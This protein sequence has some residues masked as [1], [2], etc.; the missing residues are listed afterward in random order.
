MQKI[1]NQFVLKEVA[2][3][4]E[5][6]KLEYVNP[7]SVKKEIENLEIT[8]SKED[9]VILEGIV[10]INQNELKLFD[11]NKLIEKTIASLIFYKNKL[12]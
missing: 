6:Y 7:V 9:I 8:Y 2:T 4:V 10:K 11:N 5:D 12:T 1:T 3:I